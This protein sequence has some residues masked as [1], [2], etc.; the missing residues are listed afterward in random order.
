M[1][2]NIKKEKT[3]QTL[4]AMLWNLEKASEGCVIEK[5]KGI[6]RKQFAKKH[7]CRDKNGVFV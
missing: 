4:L 5:D 3:R 1:N 6:T 2:K 7:N